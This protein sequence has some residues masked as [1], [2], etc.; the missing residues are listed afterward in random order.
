VNDDFLARVTAWVAVDPDEEDRATI[1][2]LIAD[3]DEVQLHRLFDEPL[4]FGTAGLRGPERAG[5]AGMNRCTVRRATQG[6]VAWLEGLGIAP[7]RGVVVGRDARHGSEKFNDEVVRVLLGSGLRVY[8]MPRA[9]PTPLT[10]YALRALGAAAAIMITASH[11]PAADNGFK[12]YGPDGSQIVAPHDRV[13]EGFAA[14]AGEAS[15]GERRA[16][17]H[18][19]VDEELLQSYR[20]HMVSR[21]GVASSPLRVVYTPLHG[22]G[23]E[24]MTDLFARAGFTDVTPVAEQFSP[25]ADF[26]GLAFPNPEESGVLD[27]ALATARDCDASIVVANDPD[28]DRLGAAVRDDDGAW[29]TLRGDEIGWL[30]GSVALADA[31]DNDLVA[32][33]IVSS[34]L[35][36][37]MAA[38]AGVTYATTLTGFKWITKAAPDRRLIF[39]YEEALGF[40]VD[41]VVADKDGLSAALALVRL[42]HDLSQHG[43]TLLDGID[44]L[45][46]R[47][48]VHA[49]AQISLR[50]SAPRGRE[51]LHAVMARVRDSPPHSLGGVQVSEVI[52]LETGANGR[53]PTEGLIWRLGASGRV[54]VRPSGTEPKLKAYIEVVGDPAPANVTGDRSRCVATLEAICEDVS[55]LLSL[56]ANGE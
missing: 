11:N 37:K 56:D 28:A 45:E 5:P 42:A 52:D 43:L 1:E 21:Y 18:Q 22:V 31:G 48:G 29:R 3:G 54:V 23:G 51:V 44:E 14:S 24:F 2:G 50:V 25:N 13:V 41:P 46:S 20:E 6:V 39:G 12:L 49:G 16:P 40:A 47:Y 35:L 26:P 34:T 55:H 10:A 38:R 9:L 33:T 15:L 32:T 53:A 8:E 7:Q 4:T 36:E 17:L 27:A 19:W 30:L